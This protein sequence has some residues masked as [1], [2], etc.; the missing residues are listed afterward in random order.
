M[1]G[2]YR[3]KSRRSKDAPNTLTLR[4]GYECGIGH[5]PWAACNIFSSN[6]VCGDDHHL[7]RVAD[8]SFQHQLQQRILRQPEEIQEYI[9][10]VKV[11]QTVTR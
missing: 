4:H 6:I 9:S 11:S 2:R 1:A 5:H 7:P 3:E 8:G 10:S